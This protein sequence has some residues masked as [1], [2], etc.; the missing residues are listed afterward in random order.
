[1]A[2]KPSIMPL[3]NDY[4]HLPHDLGSANCAAPNRSACTDPRAHLVHTKAMFW[5]RGMHQVCKCTSATVQCAS[6]LQELLRRGVLRRAVAARTASSEDTCLAVY[7]VIRPVRRTYTS[8]P[9]LLQHHPI[10]VG[11]ES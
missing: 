9:R 7:R 3:F 6:Q 4:P 8:R 2:L 5:R 11:G 1:M 10:A